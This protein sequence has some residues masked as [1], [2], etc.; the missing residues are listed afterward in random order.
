[1][2]C[3]PGWACAPQWAS[4]LQW[5]MP[6]LCVWRAGHSRLVEIGVAEGVSAIALR[7]G[8]NADATLWL[9][10]PFH[11]SRVRA[12]NFT[13]RVARR[14]V[15]SCGNGTVAWIEKFSQ[16]AVA[17]WKEPIDLPLIDGDHLEKSVLRDWQEG[18]R[19]IRAGGVAIFHDARVFAEGWCT[20]EY[21]PVKAVD[22]LFRSTSSGEW[23]II[24]EID[25]LVVVQRSES[26]ARNAETVLASR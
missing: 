8:M 1:M 12:L 20:P 3:V 10:D 26:A 15:K 13:R 24:E 6:L 5:S 4:I 18:S 2:L 11:L 17:S 16:D 22:H 7:E 25:S 9:V 21:G 19:F 14:T 23:T